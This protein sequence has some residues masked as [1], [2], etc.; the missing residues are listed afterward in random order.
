MRRVVMLGALCA[1]VSGGCANN[2]IFTLVL[3]LPIAPAGS[4]PRTQLV[5]EGRP[6]LAE[7][8]DDWQQWQAGGIPLSG[9]D[10]TTTDVDFVASGSAI[11]EPLRVKI[12]FCISATCTH[13]GDG[14]APEERIEFERVFYQGRYTRYEHTI[15]AAPDPTVEPVPIGPLSKCLVEGPECIDGLPGSTWCIGTEHFCER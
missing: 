6:G 7:W 12:R 9:T 14:S 3:D 13:V 5:V 10:R 11:A 2:A 15:S 1:V 8:D 4:P